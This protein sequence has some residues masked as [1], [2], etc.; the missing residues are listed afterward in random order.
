MKLSMG[1]VG[2]PNAGK[3]TL[4]N[5]M[6]KAGALVAGYPFAT[7]D[8]NIGVVPVPDSRVAALA[9]LGGSAQVTPA[10]IRFVDIAGLVRG[11]SRGEGLGNRFL[12]HIREVTGICHVVR[13]F[14]APSVAHVEDRVDPIRDIETV[15]TELAVADLET[16]ESRVQRAD[17]EATSDP[18]LRPVVRLL[19]AAEET[20]AEGTL[21]SRVPGLADQLGE[22]DDLSLLTAKPMVY[23]FNGDEAL[24]AD[25]ARMNELAEAVAPSETVFL[26]ASLESELTELD[27]ED[28]EEMLGTL[29]IEEPGLDRVVGAAF[30]ALGLQTFLTANEREA[31]AWIV[32]VGTTAVEAAAEVH[33]DFARGFVAAEVLE[34]ATLAAAGSW[35]AARA[36]GQVRTEGRS[37]VMQ[38][39]DVVEFRFNL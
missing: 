19:R 33:T 1:I 39:D 23:V 11:A 35:Q 25:P 34:F 28:A 18:G 21:I 8:P 17:R 2:L 22:L 9:D 7:I 31:R 10:A 5:A 12:A 26:D 15:E 24:L 16:L 32:P 3:S 38:P 14:D 37:Y 36:L 27:P 6:T 20:L 13:A 4:F 30:A 29:G